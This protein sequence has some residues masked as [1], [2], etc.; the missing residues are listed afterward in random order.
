MGMTVNYSLKKNNCGHPVRDDD[1]GDNLV[2][3]DAQM[4]INAD[5]I[6]VLK[7]I[8][9]LQLSFETN[10]QTATL[11]YFPFAIS[12]SKIRSIVMKELAGTNTGTITGANS[13]GASDNGVVTVAISAALNEEDEASPTTNNTVAAGSYYKLTSAKS[14][15]GG[16]VL[17]TLEYTRTA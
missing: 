9:T 5:A 15:A 1:V 11:I 3:I 2:L 6:A 10:E 13:V 12:I 17:V 14:A 8:V 7:G 16:K 4:K